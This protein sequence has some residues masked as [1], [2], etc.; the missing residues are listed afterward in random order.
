M[1]FGE[2]SK[3]R[4]IARH[5]CPKCH[6]GKLFETGSFAFS[7][8]FTMP[9][10]CGKCGQTFYPEP[11]FYYGA[12]FISYIIVSFF[13]LA[14]VGICILV[15]GW[16]VEGAFGLLLA[17]LALLYVWFFRTARSIWI[18][19]TISYDSTAIDRY[20]ATHQS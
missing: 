8:A 4:A 9:E 16:S 10:N 20:Q 2:K 5:R 19:L 14:I 11:G 15:F 13:S 12:M 7:K 18:N 3:L 6:Q 1:A 17:I